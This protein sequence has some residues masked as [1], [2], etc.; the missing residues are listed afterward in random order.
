MEHGAAYRITMTGSGLIA[1]PQ[2]AIAEQA[3]KHWR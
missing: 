1:R 2:N 3:V